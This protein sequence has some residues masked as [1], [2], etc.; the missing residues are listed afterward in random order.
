LNLLLIR[1]KVR[2]SIREDHL[3]AQED[4]EYP[5]RTGNDEDPA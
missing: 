1:R 4:F 5:A 3:L 2:L